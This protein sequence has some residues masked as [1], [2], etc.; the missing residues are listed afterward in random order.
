M[1]EA[2]QVKVDNWG[3][4][5]LQRLQQFY[6]KTLFCDLT[7]QFEDNVQL[8]VHRLVLNACTEYFQM[9]EST[10]SVV[11]DC[12]VMP[13]DLPSDVVIP[14]INFMYSGI[15]EFQ[16]SLFD[17][18]YAAAK[19]MNMFV[20]TKLLDAQKNPIQPVK[21][22]VK[23]V[24]SVTPITW[25]LQGKKI[26]TKP[27]P[28]E[29]DL[30]ETLPGRKLPIWKR[31]SAPL[32]HP[33]IPTGLGYEVLNNKPFIKSNLDEIPKPTR[34]EWPDEDAPF[35][36][37]FDEIS[38][39]SKPIIL[40]TLPREGPSKP[41]TSNSTFDEIKRSG[42]VKRSSSPIGNQCKKVNIQDVKEY[43]KEHKI[44][45]DYIDYDDSETTDNDLQTYEVDDHDS[46]EENSKDGAD[47]F[48][49]TDDIPNKGILKTEK[50]ESS[51]NKHVRFSLDGKENA[52]KSSTI[53]IQ[54]NTSPTQDVSN[55]TKIITEVL[56]KYPHLVKKNKNIRLK[57]L[58]KGANAAGSGKPLVVPNVT[59]AK[60][61]SKVNLQGL[62]YSQKYA[63]SFTM[64]IMK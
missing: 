40:P 33:Y 29:T 28:I 64:L 20:L 38:Y 7:L 57:I 47:I 59:A 25:N 23:K 32:T 13:S 22:A 34:F 62:F 48:Q 31:K 14:I 10:C 26:T 63:N 54:T 18:L 3:I 24:Q 50:S 6:N 35:D 36:S 44:R 15:L 27:P 4:F 49:Q 17:R 43:L 45:S 2:K 39:T 12:L 37:S 56:K 55:H 46:N 30:P 41:G 53:K 52:G 42:P 1:V 51:P 9:L 19:L 8:K 58:A 21:P 5:F 11:K 60:S 16:E 61:P